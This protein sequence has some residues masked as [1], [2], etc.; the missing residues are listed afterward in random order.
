MGF[1][2]DLVMRMRGQTPLKV[3]KKNGLTVGKNFYRNHSAVIDES[4][5]YMITIGD[6]VT[7]SDRVIILAHDAST[8][9]G[10]G[11]TKIAPVKIG[12]RVFIGAGSI[13]LPGVT[14][15]DDV[16]IGAGSVVTKDIPPNSVAAGNPAT[17][18]SSTDAYAGKHLENLK[19]HPKFDRS[20]WIPLS[21]EKIRELR[22]TIGDGFGYII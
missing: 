9:V 14:V 17:V 16:I 8:R 1:F 10:G 15:G 12:N 19:T 6:D 20:Y 13:L 7:I 4:H 3:L 22:E 21:E 2:G 18:I 5:A 11:Y